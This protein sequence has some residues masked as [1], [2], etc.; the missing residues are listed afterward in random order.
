[1]AKGNA[2]LDN[3]AE[4]VIH[5]SGLFD[6]VF[7]LTKYPD[8]AA[9][10]VDPLQHF[11]QH[12]AFEG[13]DPSADFSTI[14]YRSFMPNVTNAENPLLH[15]IRSGKTAMTATL[16]AQL[17]ASGLFDGAWYLRINEGVRD[18]GIDPLDHFLTFG[19]AEGRNPGPK[20]PLAAYRQRYKMQ[21]ADGTN[22]L[23]DYVLNAEHR[24]LRFT[25]DQ[26]ITL[27]RQYLMDIATNSLLGAQARF[28]A[29]YG[30]VSNVQDQHD[31]LIALF[32][33]LSQLPE[34]AQAATRMQVL[35]R[36]LARRAK[37]MPLEPYRDLNPV[38]LAGPIED[39]ILAS[40]SVMIQ[41]RADATRVILVFTGNDQRVWVPVQVFQSYLPE[42]AHIVFLRDPSHAGHKYGLNALG[43]G[44]E[45]T[46]G[47]L[48]RLIQSLGA[49]QIYCIGSST[50][51]FA[52]MRYGLDLGAERILAFVPTTYDDTPDLAK[53]QDFLQ[54]DLHLAQPPGGDDLRQVYVTAPRRADVTIVYGGA[55]LDDA[56]QAR[57]MQDV[58]SVTLIEL[59]DYAGHD[60]VSELIASGQLEV[61][62]TALV[63]PSPASS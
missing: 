16:R 54:T 47:G 62:I 41:R 2:R 24:D 20:F 34:L 52:A 26:E 13:R 12:G 29:A 9:A 38:T 49:H 36:Q 58:P 6:A 32:G 21:L 18:A 25:P 4:I 1:M 23:V 39:P 31:D 56:R 33:T 48:K 53:L 57:H 22:P 15:F 55:N 45:N 35:C 8:V 46:L 14:A 5:Q 10:G 51:G 11:I 44:Y 50:G 63:A 43:F 42:D 60:V 28:D 7:Y 3:S 40:E 19:C 17:Q 27:R 61:L 37:R 59:P 30:L